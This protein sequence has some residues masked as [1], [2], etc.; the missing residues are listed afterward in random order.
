M[1]TR[2]IYLGETDV[3]CSKDDDCN[4]NKSLTVYYSVFAAIFTCSW[5]TVQVSHLAMIPEITSIENERGVLTTIRNVGTVTSN[6]LVYGLLWF[7]L[8]I[9]TVIID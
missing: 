3:E 5:A 2:P 1:W 8:V 6:I 4:N 7:M 9:G